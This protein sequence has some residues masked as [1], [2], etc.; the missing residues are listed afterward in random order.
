M[1]LIVHPSARLAK[2]GAEID[3]L[4]D[5]RGFS[6]E[7]IGEMFRLSIHGMKSAC[8]EVDVRDATE[9]SEYIE[10]WIREL[11]LRDIGLRAPGTLLPRVSTLQRVNITKPASGYMVYDTDESSTFVWD[12]SRWILV[13]RYL[14]DP[15]LV[16]SGVPEL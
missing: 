13:G 11:G 6:L 3:A 12:G 15:N 16:Y 14:D 9:A 5:T 7:E 2:L 4:T 10:A 8:F 1:K